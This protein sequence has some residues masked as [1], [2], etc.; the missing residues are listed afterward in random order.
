MF[1]WRAT[2]ERSDRIDGHR[3]VTVYYQHGA[4]RVAYTIVSTPA[5]ATPKAPVTTLNG[6][7]FRTLSLDGRT[8]VT[9]HRAG[10]TCVLSA[11][12]VNAGALR[13][14]AAWKV[15]GEAH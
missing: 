7:M 5:L 8:V 6:T 13:E 3:A 12:G 1:G 4:A 11:T 2:G 9:W 14:L 15:P 10:H